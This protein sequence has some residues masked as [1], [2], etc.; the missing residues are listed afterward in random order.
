MNREQ[1]VLLADTLLELPT[2]DIKIWQFALIADSVRYQW[3]GI[4]WVEGWGSGGTAANKSGD[5]SFKTGTASADP[6]S[7][8]ISY[9]NTDPSLVTEI[10]IS[11]F[12]DG[13]GDASSY[14]NLMKAGTVVYIQTLNDSNRYLTC[15]LNG[16]LIDNTGWYTMD[17]TVTDNGTLPANDDIV[18]ADF[19]IQGGDSEILNSDSILNASEVP[20]GTVTAALNYLFGLGDT[21]IDVTYEELKA[22]HD[23]ALFPVGQLYRITDFRPTWYLGTYEWSH[24]DA[25]VAKFNWPDVI[26]PLIVSAISTTELNV[27]VSSELYP[28][29]VIRWIPDWD[30]NP[31]NLEKQR[32]KIIYRQDPNLRISSNFDFVGER[33]PRYAVTTSN[34]YAA[35]TTY[36][37]NARVKITNGAGDGLYVSMKGGN[38]GN[39]PDS[40]PEWW[41]IFRPQGA[42]TTVYHRDYVCDKGFDPNGYPFEYGFD[43]DESRWEL[44]PTYGF[45]S[46]LNASAGIGP[47]TYEQYYDCHVEQNNNV[48]LSGGNDAESYG[49]Y[50]VSSKIGNYG[51]TL[52]TEYFYLTKL[53]TGYEGMQNSYLFG[54]LYGYNPAESGAFNVINN[55]LEGV[56]FLGQWN[57]FEEN[58]NNILIRQGTSRGNAIGARGI[59]ANRAIEMNDTLIYSKRPN[60][61]IGNG[62]HGNELLWFR[63]TSI[64]GNGRVTHCDAIKLSS[65]QIECYI[66]SSRI[67]SIGWYANKGSGGPNVGNKF[68]SN[69]T[70]QYIDA[71][72]MDGCTIEGTFVDVAG[73]Q[74]WKNVTIPANVSMVS[75][76]FNLVEWLGLNVWSGNP[77]TVRNRVINRRYIDDDTS[78]TV[79][80]LFTDDVDINGDITVTVLE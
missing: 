20:G 7:G 19:F 57:A 43:I 60:P 56:S 2:T 65:A 26:E 15:T 67:E 73:I 78:P 29:H 61:E 74:N 66:R 31:G 63:D 5:W 76:R 72:E 40:S 12:T 58:K 22:L 17:V 44:F 28:E 4:E 34:E 71:V 25:N 23:G 41:M 18:H 35:G 59:N 30:A 42:D 53:P 77:L 80:K 75:L 16:S 11:Q 54:F 14:L 50:F 70:I 47:G 51:N 9:N 21:S 45:A 8:N 6:G 62:L 3:D 48:F 36:G 52:V 46:D 33:Y 39:D 79:E 27:I 68:L 1:L 38:I 55:Y 13:G 32:G 49:N 24:S 37:R 64:M 10:Y 69:S